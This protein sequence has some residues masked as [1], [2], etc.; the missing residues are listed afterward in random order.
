MTKQAK[1]LP[2]KPSIKMMTKLNQEVTEAIM[3]AEANP[4][5]EN[6]QR[7]KACEQALFETEPVG[8]IAWNAARL[9]IDSAQEEINELLKKK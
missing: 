1:R 5:V 4:T 7:V 3:V 2:A 8:S 6:W 9:G